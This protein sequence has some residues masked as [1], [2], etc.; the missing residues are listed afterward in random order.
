MKKASFNQVFPFSF[1]RARVWIIFG[2]HQSLLKSTFLLNKDPLVKQLGPITKDIYEKIKKIKI[3]K[4]E[5]TLAKTMK[6][7]IVSD[8]SVS[9]DVK[10]VRLPTVVTD[11]QLGIYHVCVIVSR[12]C[13]TMYH[14]DVILNSKHVFHI[15]WGG[16]EMF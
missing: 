5:L 4:S 10:S 14:R 1:K 6:R 11:F 9:T 13:D 2:I 16:A 15:F 8:V 7:K 3:F 12:L